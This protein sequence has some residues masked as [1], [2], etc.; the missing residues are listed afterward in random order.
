MSSGFGTGSVGGS[1][2]V[3][4]CMTVS[5]SILPHTLY[6]RKKYHIFVSYSYDGGA[7][8]GALNYLSLSQP[9]A[10]KGDPGPQLPGRSI[11]SGLLLKTILHACESSDQNT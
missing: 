11:P 6:V 7:V 8:V 5:R 3:A 2:I 10:L 1:S 9:S 4:L